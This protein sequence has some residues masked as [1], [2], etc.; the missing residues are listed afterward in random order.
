MGI[1]WV[2]F[3]FLWSFSF[4][5]PFSF[6]GFLSLSSY[7]DKRS[8]YLPA[9]LLL[10]RCLFPCSSCC[11][12]FSLFYYHRSFSYLHLI[13]HGPLSLVYCLLLILI[14]HVLGS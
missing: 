3:F 5:L 13:R 8:F 4:F 11:V 14:L 12:L 1:I 2:Y 10:L 6:F 7:Y 9:L